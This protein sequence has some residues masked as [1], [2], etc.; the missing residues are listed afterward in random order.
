MDNV[1][2]NTNETIDSPTDSRRGFAD[3]DEDEN[4]NI[5]K[6][7]CKICNTRYI[8]KDKQYK[9]D[10]HNDNVSERKFLKEELKM[11][12]EDLGKNHLMG[13]NNTTFSSTDDNEP[14]NATVL[15][16]LRN[17]HPNIEF[18]TFY[19]VKSTKPTDEKL[20]EHE[21]TWQDNMI[22]HPLDLDELNNDL[23]EVETRMEEQE[24]NQS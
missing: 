22:P 18:F 5:T 8:N 24:L 12:V 9:S 17:V 4:F 11:R 21:F 7:Y 13:Y 14:K 3:E 20:E 23:N 15:Q 2:N 6:C 10:Q 1:N 16:T 19:F